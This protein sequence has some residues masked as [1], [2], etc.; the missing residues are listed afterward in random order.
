MGQGI[1]LKSERNNPWFKPWFNI[2]LHTQSIVCATVKSQCLEY[3]VCI[4]LLGFQKN[5][6]LYFQHGHSRCLS[7]GNYDPIQCVDLSG[8]TDL[9]YFFSLLDRFQLSWVINGWWHQFGLRLFWFCR[10]AALHCWVCCLR[11][12]SDLRR[13]FVTEANLMSSPI[14]YPA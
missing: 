9:W 10:G 8:D 6:G 14:N 3:L 2:L 4:P 12:E 11:S 13:Q 1:N 5:G 7:N